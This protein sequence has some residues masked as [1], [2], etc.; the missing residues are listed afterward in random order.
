MSTPEN[1]TSQQPNGGAG[2]NV[3]VSP[4]ADNQRW[5]DPKTGDYVPADR[6]HRDTLLALG[7]RVISF[8]GQEERTP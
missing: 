6:A 4:T 7:R 8:A 1:T 3:I 5:F 2:G